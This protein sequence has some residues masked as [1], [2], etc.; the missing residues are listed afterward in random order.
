MMLEK[1]NENLQYKIFIS[2]HS[3]FLPSSITLL[4]VLRHC[5][6]QMVDWRS[7]MSHVVIVMHWSH[8]LRLNMMMSERRRIISLMIEP[9]RPT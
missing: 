9:H 7:L 6:R 3:S 2:S 5:V 4:D 8:H 1:E